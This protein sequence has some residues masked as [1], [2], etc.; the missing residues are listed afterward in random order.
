MLDGPVVL[1]Q[2]VSERQTFDYYACDDGKL[3]QS[4]KQRAHRKKS[5]EYT[6]QELISLVYLLLIVS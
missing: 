2:Y 6:I 3:N 4:H 5:G 1:H